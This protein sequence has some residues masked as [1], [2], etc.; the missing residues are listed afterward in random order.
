MT[1]QFELIEVNCAGC[2]EVVECFNDDEGF[3]CPY[4][5]VA[6]VFVESE[7]DELPEEEEH[8]EFTFAGDTLIPG[9]SIT[10]SHC[11]KHERSTDHIWTGARLRC[12]ICWPSWK[13]KG[14]NLRE[15]KHG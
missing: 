4:C 9:V 11:R 1:D 13:P 5:K 15:S 8:W 6:N 7:D 14:L 3:D 12:V 2:D 10:W